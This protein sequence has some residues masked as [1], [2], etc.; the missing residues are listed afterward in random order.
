MSVLVYGLSH[1]TAPVGLLERLAVPEDLLVKAL[2]DLLGRRHISEAVVLSTCNRVEVYAAVSRYHGGVADLRDFAA[3]WAGS[4]IDDIAPIAYDYYEERAA[5]HLFAVTAGLDSMVLGERQIHGQVRAAF[6]HAEAQGA[7]GRMLGALFRQSMRVAKRARLE[8]NLDGARASMVDVGLAATDR[9]LG[10]V[11]SPQVLLVGAG[12]TGSLAAERLAGRAGRLR[13][14]NRSRAR[15]EVL[16]ERH[17]GEAL[18]LEQVPAAL[19]EV[20]LVVASTA[21]AEALIG[22]D[23]VASGLADRGGRRLV[24]LDLAVP[25]NV[26]PAVGELPG[27]TVLDIDAVRTLTDAGPSGVDA[28]QARRLVDDAART[29]AGWTRSVQV[30]PTV[31]AL[32]RRAEQ[33]RVRELERYAAR[34]ASLEDPVRAHVEALTKG[35]VNTLLH[36]PSV[37][38]KRLADTRSADFYT[39]ALG[40]LFDLDIDHGPPDPADAG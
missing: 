29:F 31:A 22:V 8:T 11:P 16:A 5:A 28:A 25:R 1:R 32:H 38:L 26:D 14:A 21:S 20:D 30:E 12:Q 40:E 36:E 39:A 9:A 27:V 19:A 4:A 37:R 17:G 2:D 35:I 15:A 7:V 3:Q 24:L 23:D 10:E 33:V 13:I 6:K 18:T 34:L